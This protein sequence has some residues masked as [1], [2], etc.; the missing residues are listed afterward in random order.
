MLPVPLPKS[1]LKPSD[2]G[3][4]PELV[5]RH[6]SRFRFSFAYASPREFKRT[7]R[8]SAVT[9]AVAF[10]FALFGFVGPGGAC[11]GIAACIVLFFAALWLLGAIQDWR[12]YDPDADRV[13]DYLHAATLESTGGVPVPGWDLASSPESRTLRREQARGKLDGGDGEFHR[14]ILT[15]KVGTAFEAARDDADWRK[16]QRL[17]AWFLWLSLKP[18]EGDEYPPARLN[19]KDPQDVRFAKEVLAV[20]HRELTQEHPWSTLPV[21]PGELFTL[22]RD[23]MMSVVMMAAADLASLDLERGGLGALGDHLTRW[24]QMGS[25]LSGPGSFQVLLRH[26]QRV[27]DA[28]QSEVPTDPDANEHF[29]QHL[30]RGAA[31]CFGPHPVVAGDARVNSSDRDD[32]MTAGPACHEVGASRIPSRCPRHGRSEDTRPRRGWRSPRPPHT[33]VSSR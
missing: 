19:S 4:T 7:L 1:S 6:K 14:R 9:A 26:H 8:R 12:S 22:S 10:L 3:G 13:R 11:L 18:E 23:T 27:R 32:T 20:C 17:A 24:Q 31:S 2:F 33:R 5:E 16:R 15:D 21:W 29:A 25:E 28:A 30:N